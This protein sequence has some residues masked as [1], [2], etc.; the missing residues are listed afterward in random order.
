M[1]SALVI[2]VVLACLLGAGLV[3]LLLAGGRSSDRRTAIKQLEGAA[4]GPQLLAEPLRRGAQTQT[5]GLADISSASGRTP[6]GASFRFEQVAPSASSGSYREA[7]G[8][9]VREEGSTYPS[10]ATLT[11]S[12]DG[13]LQEALRYILADPQ[14]T[15]QGSRLRSQKVVV[16]RV[17]QEAG[18][19]VLS[20]LLPRAACRLPSQKLSAVQQH[21]CERAGITPQE[22]L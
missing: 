10:Q 13:D 16:L 4:A 11:V 12:G 15:L 17:Q 8:T 9:V 5:R 21:A 19:L 14:L 18:R 20:G 1:P 6:S 22:K 7:D 2:G 3:V